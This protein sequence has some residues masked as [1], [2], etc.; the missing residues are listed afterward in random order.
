[1]AFSATV[2]APGP[3]LVAV[4]VDAMDGP[5]VRFRHVELITRRPSEVRTDL[6]DL[7]RR[8]GATVRV[9]WSGDP[10]VASWGLSL[11]AALEWGMSS[12]G[13]VERRDTM[14][15]S[16]LF[17]CPELADDPYRHDAVLQRHDVREHEPNPGAWPV[18]P[19]HE[20]P[21]WSWTPLERVGPLRFGMS[22]LQV[23]AAL[24][25]VAPAARHGHF[26][27]P[28]LGAPAPQVS[29]AGVE[30]IGRRVSAVDAALARRAKEDSIRVLFGGGGDL[31]LEGFNMFVRAARAGDAVVSESRFGAQ[32]W[33]D[34]G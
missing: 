10:E 31:G 34:H 25:G 12:A 11:G 30:L 6:H 5:L 22:A 17:A 7:A 28:L 16:A 15:T 13:S 19:A 27:G 4:V 23:A 14:V 9:S 26:P 24:G 1:M 32:D 20:R 33:D 2:Y 21:R 8:E 29:Y 3:R 18:R